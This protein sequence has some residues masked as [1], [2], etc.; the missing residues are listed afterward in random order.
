MSHALELV[1]C[2][3]GDC[4]KQLVWSRHTETPVPNLMQ[5]DCLGTASLTPDVNADR[6]INRLLLITSYRQLPGIGF[7]QVHHLSE[8]FNQY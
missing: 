3:Q 7:L 6:S 8:H 5:D 4:S 2:V 1:R